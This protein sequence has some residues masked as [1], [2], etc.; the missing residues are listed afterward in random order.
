MAFDGPRRYDTLPAPV[1][2]SFRQAREADLPLLCACDAYAQAHE[3]RRL[4]LRRM[5][6]QSLCLLAMGKDEPLGY[7]V[8]EYSFFGHGFIPLVC[9]G[10][11]HQGEGIGLGLLAELERRC[12]TAKLFTSSNASNDRAKRLFL[13]AGFVRSGTIENLD[14]GD[15]ECVYF[16]TVATRP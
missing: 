15:P 1:T 2:L 10:A 13:R 12:S 16:K 14:E 6:A 5:L 7:A 4:E 9:V 8:L 3:S 11:A